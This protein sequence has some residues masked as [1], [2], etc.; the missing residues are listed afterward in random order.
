MGLVKVPKIQCGTKIVWPRLEHLLAYEPV[1]PHQAPEAICAEPDHGLEAPLELAGAKAG[2]TGK[3]LKTNANG[4]SVEGPDG[5]IHGRIHLAVATTLSPQPL[6]EQLH[7]ILKGR[8]S[9]QVIQEL[10]HDGSPDFLGR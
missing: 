10:I 2:G 6:A 8:T 4:I 1:Q 7:L 9:G 5:S 3:H